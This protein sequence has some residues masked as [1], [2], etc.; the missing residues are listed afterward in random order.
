MCLRIFP[1]QRVRQFDDEAIQ[2]CAGD[3]RGC[4]EVRLG[5]M[6]RLLDIL[7]NT[8]F[9]WIVTQDISASQ[10]RFPIFKDGAEVEE[11]NIVRL[12]QSIWRIFAIGVQGVCARSDDALMPILFDSK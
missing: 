4:H 9:D 12:N 3:V 2:R 1:P 5:N 8:R 6:P 10:V 11:H 7:P